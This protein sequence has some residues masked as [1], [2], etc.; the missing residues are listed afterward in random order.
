MFIRYA[1]ARFNR[2][3]AELDYR[4]YFTELVRLHGQGKT[5]STSLYDLMHP[6]PE[7]NR[8][9]EEIAAEVSARAGLEVRG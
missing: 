5:Y 7:D 1:V 9:A 8:T 6:K 2:H 4:Y 3:T